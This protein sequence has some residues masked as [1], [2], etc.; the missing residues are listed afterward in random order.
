MLARSSLAWLFS[1]LVGL[2]IYSKLARRLKYFPKK[3]EETVAH[4]IT[5]INKFGS[6]TE[7]LAIAC[8]L[9]A[10]NGLISLAVLDQCLKDHLVN[11]GAFF[12]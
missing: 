9:F 2:L 5:Y 3:L 4:L 11:D 7:K 10:A 1:S 6:N 8:G 12:T